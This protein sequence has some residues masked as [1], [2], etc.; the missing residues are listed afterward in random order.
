MKLKKSFW[1]L[2]LLGWLLSACQGSCRYQA[3]LITEGEHTLTGTT[4]GDLVM[5]GGEAVI[6]E[7]AV[8]SGST[9]LLA[10][11]LALRGTIT[12]NLTYLNG[13]LVL[14][15]GARIEGD[16][17]LPGGELED[18]DPATVGGK[19]TTGASPQVPDRLQG[20]NLNAGLT[21]LRWLGSS[22]LL[23]AAAAVLDRYLPRQ[24][25]NAAEAA[26]DHLP[27]A[28]A[29]GALAGIT[30]LT[31]LVLMAYTIILLPVSFLGLGL[32]GLAV[33]YSWAA[34][35]RSL[36]HW[37]SEKL[38]LAV[39]PR[40]S[41]FGGTVVFFLIINILGAIPAVG[42]LISL[43]AAAAGLGSVYLTRFGIRKF[44]PQTALGAEVASPAD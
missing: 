34:C 2:F 15:P 23:G 22:L 7:G 29:M 33:I 39:G 5:L 28:L 44:I 9:H 37:V 17:N 12:G 6:P 4:Y 1:I 10:G 20:G 43:L 42:G 16:L 24:L 35:G 18:L 19:I 21:I 3:T 26:V 8:L 41:A 36:G 13:D 14:D 30:G 31:L 11:K 27:V 40:W 32:L 25:Q 38:D